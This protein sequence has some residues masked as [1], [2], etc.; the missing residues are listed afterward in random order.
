MD[1]AL[2]EHHVAHT[3][4][5]E[6]KRSAGKNGRYEAKFKVLGESIKHHIKEEEGTMFSEAENADLDWEQL[7]KKAIEQKKSL[8]T[9]KERGG[10]DNSRRRTVKSR[11][12]SKPRHLRK[13]A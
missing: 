8:M 10:G 4:I 6:L 13:A 11:R 2:E 12:R 1:E 9:R 7:A 5:N 3:L